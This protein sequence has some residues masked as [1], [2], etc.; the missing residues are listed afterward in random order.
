[1]V[2]ALQGLDNTTP[3]FLLFFQKRTILERMAK[4]RFG[5]LMLDLE[6][7]DLILQMLQYFCNGITTSHPN[8]IKTDMQKI[9]SPILGEDRAI[10]EQLR[11]KLLAIWRKEL[12]ASP[13]A[14]ELVEGLI[15]QS[16]K[17]LRKKLTKEELTKIFGDIKNELR[18]KGLC[19]VCKGVWALDHSCLDNK[20]A[21]R[22]EKLETSSD[23]G[24][25]S[26]DGFVGFQEKTYEGSN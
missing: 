10:C 2:E 15:K 5:M 1:M 18:R 11:S 23:H 17:L 22:I 3:P 26:I 7:D 12:I 4:F 21:T 25:S 14:Y 8:F 6:C 24:D 9:M 20:E 19:F 16:I 13:A